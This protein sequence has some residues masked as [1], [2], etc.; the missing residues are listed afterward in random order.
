MIQAWLIFNSGIFRVKTC[1]FATRQTEAWDYLPG[2]F[3]TCSQR[4]SSANSILDHQRPGM[5][6]IMQE[7]RSADFLD[8]SN[9]NK[10]S[11]D[12]FH[13][14]WSCCVPVFEMQW[15]LAQPII[16]HSWV[17]DML[18]AGSN[19]LKYHTVVQLPLSVSRQKWEEWQ[20]GWGCWEGSVMVFI[21]L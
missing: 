9:I 3:C 6:Q 19:T 8:S 16:R 17:G 5:S 2:R 4:Q 7:I 20:G 1:P 11:Y 10:H 18:T 15:A 12:R 21:K 13:S 14:L